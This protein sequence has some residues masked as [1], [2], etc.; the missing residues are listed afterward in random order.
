MAD[1]FQVKDGNGSLITLKSTDTASVHAPAHRVTDGTNFLPAGDAVARPIFFKLTDGTNTA[2]SLDVAGRAGFVVPT[3]AAASGM[4]KV[5]YRDL[6]ATV[7]ALKAAAGTLYG[8]QVLNNQAAAAYIQIFDVAAASVTLATTT[9][10]LEILVPA[11]SQVNVVLPVQGVPFATAIA[12][13]STTAEKGS[14]GSNAGVQ[15]FAQYV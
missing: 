4:S 5:K 6:A 13:A 10:D 3:G 8:L 14:T 15:V 11:N 9:P 2:P 12:I 7:Q 1:N